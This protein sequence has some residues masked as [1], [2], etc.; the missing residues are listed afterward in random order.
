MCGGDWNQGERE[1]Q[2][3]QVAPAREARGMGREAG[4]GA[5]SGICLETGF[6][7]P[8]SEEVVQAGSLQH[9]DST[10]SPETPRVRSLQGKGHDVSS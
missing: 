10:E 4:D 6:P 2:G 1:H 7:N 9:E 8:Q 3:S 5:W